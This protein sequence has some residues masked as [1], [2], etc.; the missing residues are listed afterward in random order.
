MKRLP[1]KCACQ[2]NFTVD[3]ALPCHLGGFMIQ[4]HNNVRDM[5]ANLLREVCHDVSLEPTGC[6]DRKGWSEISVV[7]Q[8][9]RCEGRCQRKWILDPVPL[10]IFDVKVCNLIAP[11][12]HEKSSCAT[13]SSMEK[14]KKRSYNQRI[15]QIDKGTFTPL[16]FGATGGIARE[17]SIFLS[18]LADKLAVKKKCAKSVIIS[19]IRRKISFLLIRWIVTCLRGERTSRPFSQNQLLMND[20]KLS[21][22][23]SSF[24]SDWF[25][26][27]IIIC[28]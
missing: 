4:R 7:D 24:I 13:F 14:Q 19:N 20:P 9:K 6:D 17:C 12:Y 26:I 3:H 5:T 10:S 27:C 2:A 23:S 16:I 18:K 25:I 21:E 28:F 22:I 1:V 11:S 8:R 15:Q